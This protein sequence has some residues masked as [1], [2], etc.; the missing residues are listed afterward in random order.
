AAGRSNQLLVFLDS[1]GRAYTVPAHDLASAR[2]QGEPL[3]GRVRP[4]DGAHFVAPVLG[5]AQDRYVLASDRGY[6][7]VARL[8]E[9]QS[10]NRA[11]KAVVTVPRGGQV[12]VPSPVRGGAD[13]RLA[14]V[15]RDGRLLIFPLD[16]LP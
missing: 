7:F 4:S 12:L 10:R 8:G 3:S 14:V 5:D 6:G 1:H 11:G 9:L 16:T 2:G 13:E 15:T